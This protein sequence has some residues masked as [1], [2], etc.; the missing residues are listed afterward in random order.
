MDTK[1]EL[2]PS[3]T[4]WMITG[5]TSGLGR[6][7]AQAV[8]KRGWNAVITARHP[9][10][11]NSF[12]EDYPNRVLLLP[13]DVTDHHAIKQAVEQA[14]ERFGTVDVLVN[15]AGYGY[16]AAVEEGNTDDVTRLFATH[17]FG[18]VELIKQ[19]LPD[20]RL[21]RNGAIINVSSIAALESNPGSGYYAGAKSAQ[22]GI[23]WALKKELTPLGIRVM[24]VE[25][26]A[27]RTEFA[28][29]S[30]TE[31]KVVI[32]DYDDTA[33]KRRLGRDHTHGTQP[34]DPAKAAELIIEAITSPEPPTH[35]LLGTDAVRF[36]QKVLS[37]R[38]DECNQWADFSAR[39]DF[40][41][42]SHNE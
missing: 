12:I 3:L 4:T 7:M 8:L 25:P 14:K 13:L 5:C 1:E 21:N 11:L 26:G 29:R 20:M 19:V 40:K 18:P 6:S 10:Q 35:L 15:N 31:S 33:G 9:E 38:L 23:S 32:H 28:G 27:F 39:S 30:L 36:A 16:R 37:R 42:A 22:E 24:V 2:I 41:S 34:G 17:V